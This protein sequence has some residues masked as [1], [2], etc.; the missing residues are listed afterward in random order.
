[1]IQGSISHLDL[2]LAPYVLLE[3]WVK[4]IGLVS[5]DAVTVVKGDALTLASQSHR[6]FDHAPMFRMQ[7]NI[8]TQY[9]LRPFPR[10]GAGLQGVSWTNEALVRPICK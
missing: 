10:C 7:L 6:D 5:L 4:Y 3:V 2:D 9:P 1:M 8:L